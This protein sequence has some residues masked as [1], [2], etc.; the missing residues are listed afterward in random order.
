[1]LL[2]ARNE[3]TV[4]TRCSFA[5]LAAL[6]CSMLQTPGKDSWPASPV[7]N[8]FWAGVAFIESYVENRFGQ[9]VDVDAISKKIILSKGGTNSKS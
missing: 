2:F 1:M 3:I 5:F 6:A 4:A 7:S 8:H 9:R